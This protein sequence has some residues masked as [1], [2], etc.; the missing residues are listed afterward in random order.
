[1]QTFPYPITLSPAPVST[2]VCVYCSSSNRIDERYTPVAA[3]LGRGLAE[4]GHTL[5]YG[6]GN[7][8]LMG[9]VARTVH[10][11]GG[12]VVGV[13]PERL[14]S[15]EGVAYDFADEM[16]VTETMQQRKAR[17][18]ERSEGFVVLPGGYG[19]L[20]EFMEVLTLKQLRYHHRALTLVN[21]DGF[22]DALLTFFDQLH[23][24]R[25]CRMERDAL[26]HVAKA[27]E[28][29][30]DYIDMHVPTVPGD[31]N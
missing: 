9:V 4:R 28:D 20:E 10:E 12:T 13:I 5:I 31:R 6:G 15:I 21:T 26:F 8:G 16:I 2:Q 14:K 22:F 7:V 18:F 25:F 11:Y 27:P 3:A 24:E 1:M 17:M 19:T 29:A 30:L 23:R